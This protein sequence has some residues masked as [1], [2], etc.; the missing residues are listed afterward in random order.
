[1]K[2]AFCGDG[3]LWQNVEQCDDG[4]KNDDDAC[5]N[6][7]KCGLLTF[8]DPSQIQGWQRN[9]GWG[10]YTE[11][12]PSQQEPWPIV[13]QSRGTVFGTDGNRSQPYPGGEVEN[14]QAI[15]TPFKVPAKITF[16]S[17]HV[18]EGSHPYDTET[19][20]LSLNGG[21]S[22]L[23]L[24][25][26]EQDINPQTFCQQRNQ[27]GADDWDSIVLDTAAWQGQTGILRFT[28]NT[29]DDCCDFE[30]GWFIDNGKFR[31]CQ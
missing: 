27:R 7:C 19:I 9:G 28:Y 31:S 5:S 10:L 11:A 15:T 2:K 22:W 16:L 29:G 1:C 13:F 20:G 8:E 6:Q 17:W 30:R 23:M 18:D 4:N 24:V 12:P 21:Q 3:V 25:D 26:C 14:S